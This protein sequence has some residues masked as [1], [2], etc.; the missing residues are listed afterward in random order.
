M[1]LKGNLDPARARERG[2]AYPPSRLT[3]S[4]PSALAMGWAT[5]LS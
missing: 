1:A 5:V 4:R 2:S 3:G